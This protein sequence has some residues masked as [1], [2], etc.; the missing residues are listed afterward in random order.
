MIGNDYILLFCVFLSPRISLIIESIRSNS[1]TF[2]EQ[3]HYYDLDC[4]MKK[5]VQL[6]AIH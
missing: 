2:G 3:N 5:L 1:N 6:A 4:E